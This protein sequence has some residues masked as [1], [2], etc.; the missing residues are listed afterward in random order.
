[1]RGEAG[2]KGGGEEGGVGSGREDKSE[3]EKRIRGGK[4]GGG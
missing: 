4:G 2:N 3:K 1:V